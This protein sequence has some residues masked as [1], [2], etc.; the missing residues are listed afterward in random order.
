MDVERT[1]SVVMIDLGQNLDSNIGALY[2]LPLCLDGGYYD[3][4]GRNRGQVVAAAKSHQIYRL[5]E[6]SDRLYYMLLKKL[7]WRG[8]CFSRRHMVAIMYG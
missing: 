7:I 5:E 2:F 3:D 6:K 8:S 1:H 4:D